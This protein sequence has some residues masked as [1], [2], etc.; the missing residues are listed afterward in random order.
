MKRVLY[1]AYVYAAIGFCTLLVFPS[2]VLVTLITGSH[3]IGHR[4]HARFWGRA[5]LASCGVRLRVH[6]MQYLDPAGAYVFVI[7]HNS[8]FS[9]YAAA[10][11]LP[12]QWRAVLGI[13][14]RRIPVFAWIALLAGHIF[15][16]PRNTAAA[17]ETLKVAA[18]KMRTGLSVLI[19]P[20]GRHHDGPG[21]LPFRSGGF[22][23]AVQA[24]VPIIPLVAV[25]RR[26]PGRAGIVRAVDLYIEPPVPTAGCTPADVP[27]LL[28]AARR[29]MLE[30]LDP[31]RGET[32]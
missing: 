4:V 25:E 24:Q 1:L 26:R 20:E 22:H 6:G 8:H 19:F 32:R 23:L 3:R 21:L 16:D 11:A 10:A 13:K 27:A 7:N 2:S 15:I 18:A 31:P 17:V 12:H 14:L 5:I 29:T 30:R 9:G 28:E